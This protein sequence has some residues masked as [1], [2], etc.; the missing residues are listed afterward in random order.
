M[1]SDDFFS[2]FRRFIR[3]ASHQKLMLLSKE[4]RVATK[5]RYGGGRKAKVEGV[6]RG[7]TFEE[8]GRFMSV[9]EG[10][11]KAAFMV[12]AVLGLRVGELCALRGKDF[13]N[14]RLRVKGE[15]GGF[16]GYFRLPGPILAVMPRRKPQERLFPSHAMLRRHFIAYRA[17][18]G[19]AEV[20]A[21]AEPG[22]RNGR[23]VRPLFR[24]SMHSLRHFTIETCDRLRRDPNLNRVVARHTKMDTQLRYLTYPMQQK[25]DQV[26][27]EI[28]GIVD[29]CEKPTPHVLPSL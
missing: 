19:L 8:L 21:H 18:A 9:A 11:Y 25:V 20:Y 14:G 6:H 3:T 28:A 10:E 24:L 17:K 29:S 16:S 7:F 23:H 1:H 22:G 12:M 26:I 4:L 27:C 2:D 13:E 15:K 5:A